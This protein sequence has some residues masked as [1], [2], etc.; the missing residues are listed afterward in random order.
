M[1]LHSLIPPKWVAFHD[2]CLSQTKT[3]HSLNHPEK[4]KTLSTPPQSPQIAKLRIHGAIGKFTYVH[5]GG[6]LWMGSIF[7]YVL[8]LPPI[9]DATVAND[10]LGIPDP[11]N[12][13]S[14]WRWLECWREPK[15]YKYPWVL[16][17]GPLLVISG[18][19]TLSMALNMC[20]WGEKTY[21]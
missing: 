3:T 7:R 1:H 19:V 20:N 17:D 11:S 10:Y 12:V 21:L 5:F 13:M 2:P 16:Q 6:I 14:S 4:K 8:D 18:V 15:V 9:Q